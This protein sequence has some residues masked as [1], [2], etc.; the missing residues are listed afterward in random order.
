AAAVRLT[1]GVLG[2]G[3]GVVGQQALSAGEGAKSG[4]VA[5]PQAKTD[6][7]Q[8]QGTWVLQSGKTNGQ[9]APASFVGALKLV[10]AGDKVSVLF[11]A[12][13]KKEGTFTLKATAQPKEID[14]IE[15]GKP[16]LCIYRL[17]GDE[18]TVCLDGGAQGRARAGRQ[19]PPAPRHCHAQLP[20]PE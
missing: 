11:N 5:P 1:L 6:K 20:R 12:N 15:N 10:F 14:L 4:K 17:Q 16:T 13:V 3:A 18:L 2:A 7:G 8:L 9:D 19:Q